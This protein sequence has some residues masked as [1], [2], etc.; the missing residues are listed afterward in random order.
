[1]SMH[2]FEASTYW[3]KHGCDTSVQFD[4][5]YNSMQT[6]GQPMTSTSEKQAIATHDYTVILS[7]VGHHIL[8]FSSFVMCRH[9][10]TNARRLRQMC[11]AQPPKYKAAIAA[12]T[13][14]AVSALHALWA[15]FLVFFCATGDGGGGAGAGGKFPDPTSKRISPVR[16]RYTNERDIGQFGSMIESHHY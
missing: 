16:C 2:F 5:T 4:H 3:A 13:A 15:L 8:E 14:T 7:R 10:N 12:A 9:T 1:M 11:Q 6:K